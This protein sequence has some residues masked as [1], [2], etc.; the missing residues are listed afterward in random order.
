MSMN[1]NVFARLQYSSL[2]VSH[3]VVLLLVPHALPA[4]LL[5]LQ[6]LGSVLPVALLLLPH[7]NSEKFFGSSFYR[8]TW[9][10]QATSV[11]NLLFTFLANL[12]A[13]KS[14]YKTIL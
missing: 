14:S 9:A 7:A 12:C 1:I 10:P 8:K 3:E 6:V 2:L 13:Y 5:P 4:L 11:K